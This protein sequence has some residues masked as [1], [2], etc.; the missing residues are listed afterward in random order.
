L[1][2]DDREDEQTY[3]AYLLTAPNIEWHLILQDT[4]VIAQNNVPIFDIKHW[5]E[6]Q[7]FENMINSLQASSTAWWYSIPRIDTYISNNGK[8]TR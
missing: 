8:R 3:T 5:I 7:L 1:E 2:K 6:S 4:I